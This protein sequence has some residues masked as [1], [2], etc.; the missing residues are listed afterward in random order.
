MYKG[1]FIVIDGT[2][3]SGKKTQTDLLVERLKKEGYAVE[4]IDFPQYGKK[5]AGPVEDYLNWEYGSAS[6]VTPYQASILY[7]VDRFAASAQIKE[8]LAQGKIVVSDR[9]VSAN[10]GHQ[11]GK[12]DDLKERDRFLERLDELEYG[13]LALPKPDVQIFLYVDPETS[14]KLALQVKKTNM[15][16]SKDIHENDAEHMRKASEAFHYVAKKY[17]WATINGA[18]NWSLLPREV[19]SDLIRDEIIKTINK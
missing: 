4:K 14:R 9:Y 2:D 6:D 13:I 19:I 7:A 11:A 16:K 12:I 17:N 8:W 15:D 3:G 10:M 5:S 1:K 18:P